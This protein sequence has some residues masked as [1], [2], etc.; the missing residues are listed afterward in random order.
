MRGATLRVS[1]L[2]G[3]TPE[4]LDRELECHGARVI[5]GLA[6]PVDPDDPFVLPGSA[7]DIDVRPAKDG[8]LIGIAGF[9]ADD[10]G[11]IF[12]RAQA[13]TKAPQRPRPDPRGAPPR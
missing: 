13:F 7:L 2:P 1:A 10:A 6:K 9:S 11:K 8:F 4:W 12:H 3:V 5:L